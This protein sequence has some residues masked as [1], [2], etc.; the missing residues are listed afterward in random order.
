M[1][2]LEADLATWEVDGHRVV[3]SVS[4]REELYSGACVSDSPD[5]I[6]ELN[7]RDDYSY[8]LLPSLRVPSGTTWRRPSPAST[9]A[10]RASA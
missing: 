2:R 6:L 1:S 8:T 9:W 10:V 4:T 5:V 3:K 7:L